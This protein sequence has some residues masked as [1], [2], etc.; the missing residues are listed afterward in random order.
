MNFSRLGKSSMALIFTFLMAVAPFTIST[1][2]EIW[3][4]KQFDSVIWDGDCGK[5]NGN[6]AE[7]VLVIN[8]ANVKK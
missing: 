8:A 2:L 1:E 5:I 6:Q 7:C 3:R 4:K